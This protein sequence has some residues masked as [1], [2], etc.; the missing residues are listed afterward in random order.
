MFGCQPEPARAVFENV[1]H[2]ALRKSL[3][4]CV[5]RDVTSIVDGEPTAPEADPDPVGAVR[6]HD[7]GFAAADRIAETVDGAVL[8]SK[9]ASL[10]IAEPQSAVPLRCDRANLIPTPDSSGGR[11]RAGRTV[12]RPVA[13]RQAWWRPTE[14]LACLRG[15][16]SRCDQA[17]RRVRYRC[18]PQSHVCA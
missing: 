4:R 7:I 15:A 16:R 12:P 9:E 8:P 3:L 14:C 10:L 11:R 2:R 17:D 13:P 18:A 5:A 1:V 6:M